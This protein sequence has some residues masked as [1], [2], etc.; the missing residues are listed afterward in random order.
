MSDGSQPHTPRTLIPLRFSMLLWGPTRTSATGLRG[1]GA[2]LCLDT[3][4]VGVGAGGSGLLMSAAHCRRQWFCCPPGSERAPHAF[5]LTR[6]CAAYPGRT[7][8]RP[9]A[10]LTRIR[11]S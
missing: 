1:V 3:C 9:Q 10:T 11:L 2:F 7:C 6:A 4:S 5:A 8:L